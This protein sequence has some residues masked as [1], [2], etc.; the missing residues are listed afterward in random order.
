MFRDRY[1]TPR[2]PVAPHHRRQRVGQEITGSV[3]VGLPRKTGRAETRTLYEFGLEHL[4][5]HI[6]TDG[7]VI[8]YIVRHEHL[9]SNHNSPRLELINESQYIRRGHI[10]IGEV[11][12]I[13]PLLKPHN[14]RPAL[15]DVHHGFLIIAGLTARQVLLHVDVD[16]VGRYVL[17][18]ELRLVVC[19]HTHNRLFGVHRTSIVVPFHLAFLL[20]HL[21]RTLIRLPYLDLRFNPFRYGTRSPRSA[22]W[23]V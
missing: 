2:K 23:R 4:R 17:T 5:T 10:R 16:P 20:M 18:E 22:L 7:L 12:L 1:Y 15:P 21:Q 8:P 9:I 14:H 3:Q 11:S 19:H 6:T 13:V